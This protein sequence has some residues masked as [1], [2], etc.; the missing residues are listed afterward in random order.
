MSDPRCPKCLRPMNIGN[1]PNPQEC[2]E[3]DD[4]EG[5]CEAYAEVASLRVSA[6]KMVKTARAW[7]ATEDTVWTDESGYQR[8][9]ACNEFL[10]SLA[11]MESKLGVR[12]E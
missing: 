4:D 9:K 11:A 3:T 8:R 6:T 12:D 2:T 5:L 1:S 7:F 10:E